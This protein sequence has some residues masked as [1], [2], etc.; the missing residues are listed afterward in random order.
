MARRGFLLVTRIAQV[1]LYKQLAGLPGGRVTPGTRPKAPPR[2]VRGTGE[3]AGEPAWT[4]RPGTA[5]VKHRLC[6]I[7]AVPIQAPFLFP[8]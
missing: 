7:Y 3:M 5:Q 6:W 1:K 8:A 2:G 4:R